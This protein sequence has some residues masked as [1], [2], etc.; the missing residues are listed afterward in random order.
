MTS[1]T[2]NF[3]TRWQKYS[4]LFSEL[5]KR[6]F[7]KKYKRTFLGIIWSMLSP[8][9]QLL[10]MALVFTRFFGR[11]VEHFIIYLFAGNLVFS[12]FKESTNGGMQAL[13]SNAEIITKINTPKYLF[14]LSKNVSALINFALTLVIFFIFAAADGVVFHPRFA[15]LIFPVVCLL[16]FNIGVGLILSALFVFFKDIQYLYDIFTMLLMYFSAIFY[17]VESFSANV[18]R[19]YLLNPVYAY[20]HYFRLV[21]LYG[22]VPSVSV[23]LICGLYAAAALLIGGAFYKRYN[24]RFLYYL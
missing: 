16:V 24:Y 10:V 2:N 1:I 19:L 15:L 20:I 11:N 9:L 8:L 6:D 14:L 5:V 12:Y 18:Q 4:F 23:H 3:K 17:T 22:V 7:K 13:K 21:V